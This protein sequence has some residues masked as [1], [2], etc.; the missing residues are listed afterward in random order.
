MKGTRRIPTGSLQIDRLALLS[1]LDLT[2]KYGVSVQ[3]L[4]PIVQHETNRCKLTEG[5]HCPQTVQ[6][7][8]KQ[9]RKKNQQILCSCLMSLLVPVCSCLMY[10]GSV[11]SCL[12]S[13]LRKK[14]HQSACSGLMIFSSP[15]SFDLFCT[16]RIDNNFVQQMLMICEN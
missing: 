1:K 6:L 5:D 4:F 2:K 12:M 3:L 15:V 14:D 9:V 16:T 11:C 7:S 8:L 10:V 13:L